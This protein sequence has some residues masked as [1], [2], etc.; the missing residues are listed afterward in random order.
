LREFLKYLFRLNLEHL[1]QKKRGEHLRKNKWLFAVTFAVLGIA[2]I[3]AAYAQDE[4]TPSL[5]ASP[6]NSNIVSVIGSGFDP[7]EN[8]TLNL[9]ANETTFYTFS[10][11]AATDEEGNFS[12]ILIV[13]TSLSGTYNLTASTSDASAYVEYTVPDLTGPQGETGETGA[14]G[15]TGVTGETGA[16]GPTG[17]SADPIT[18]YAGIGLGL[19]ATVL[20]LI[21]L[22][23]KR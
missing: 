19:L 22:T 14:T 2:L 6:D 5:N 8:V 11:S 7:S 15:A 20:A 10:E 9:I 12:G 17:A 21:A 1:K 18:G 16:T 13:P 23:R 3:S 4:L